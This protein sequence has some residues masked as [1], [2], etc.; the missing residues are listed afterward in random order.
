[1][2]IAERAHLLSMVR[3]VPG[4]ED[5]TAMGDLCRRG[6][7]T[8]KTFGYWDALTVREVTTF[9]ELPRTVSQTF[10]D[11]VASNQVTRSTAELAYTWDAC[12]V[13]SVGPVPRVADWPAYRCLGVCMLKIADRDL[14]AAGLHAITSARDAIVGEEPR[15]HSGQVCVGA[16]LSWTDIVL[17]LFAD[18]FPAIAADIASVT[19]ALVAAQTPAL[20]TITIPCYSYAQGEGTAQSGDS[21]ILSGSAGNCSRVRVEFSAGFIADDVDAMADLAGARFRCEPSLVLGESDVALRPE[22]PGEQFVESLLNFRREIGDELLDTTT[23]LVYTQTSADERPEAARGRA[24]DQRSVGRIHLGAA[25]QESTAALEAVDAAL[26]QNLSALVECAAGYLNDP[27]TL[28]G[29][30]DLVLPLETLM[31]EIEGNTDQFTDPQFLSYLW[32]A[33]KDLSIALRQRTASMQRFHRGDYQPPTVA[34]EASHKMLIAAGTYV[35]GLLAKVD[36]AWYGCMIADWGSDFSRLES[37]T[38]TIPHDHL[39]RPT[40]WW[41]LGH[42]VGHE[43]HELQKERVYRVD[44]R[45][46][47]YPFPVEGLLQRAAE[48]APCWLCHPEGFWDEIYA[49]V[50]DL[51][52]AMG[53]D[54]EFYMRHAWVYVQKGLY[55]D[56]HKIAEFSFRAA[57]VAAAAAAAAGADGL[58][59]DKE[60]LGTE[61]ARCVVNRFLRNALPLSCDEFREWLVDGTNAL[62]MIEV[63]QAWWPVVRI[64]ALDVLSLRRPAVVSD[65]DAVAV[66]WLRGETVPDVPDPWNAIASLAS[67]A[68]RGAGPALRT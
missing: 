42:E 13:G 61:D 28:G 44:L 56:E 59:Y 6:Q 65:P 3:F 40:R 35:R 43:C 51:V 33:Y 26:A 9:S 16:G 22:M 7:P 1:M 41:G 19:S 12:E 62:R 63:V 32:N 60:E 2:L 39:A 64:T 54:W 10:G 27:L 11:A 8:Y 46:Y 36:E 25:A 4:R 14:C 53:G 34:V 48:N 45:Q 31:R 67:L 29:F 50:F 68:N 55:R 18:G 58:S 49:E 66:R 21:D 17:L 23:R 38:I 5:G 15:L 47:G 20:K 30:L 37:R 57:L 52:V 24:P